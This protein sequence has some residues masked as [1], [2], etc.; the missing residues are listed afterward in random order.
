MAPDDIAAIAAPGALT[1]PA[2]G[3]GHARP[4]RARAARPLPP[5]RQAMERAPEVHLH[6]RGVTTE[7][8]AAILRDGHAVNPG[9]GPRVT[10]AWPK[11]E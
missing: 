6:F 3:P 11:R 1:G 9:S 8:V 10:P 4:H 2:R 5:P 7:D